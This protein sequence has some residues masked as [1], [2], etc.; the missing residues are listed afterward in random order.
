MPQVKSRQDWA[1][2]LR[3]IHVLWTPGR[4][5]RNCFRRATHSSYFYVML[6]RETLGSAL[7]KPSYPMKTLGWV[8]IGCTYTHI[9][10]TVGFRTITN[11]SSWEL[12]N[13]LCLKSEPCMMQPCFSRLKSYIHTEGGIGSRSKS[14]ERWL[15]HIKLHISQQSALHLLHMCL[16]SAQLKETMFCNR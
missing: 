8:S 9:V 7:R 15:Q 1:A 4:K 12:N 2:L 16:S 3:K 6:N 10:E 5:D 13:S 11:R 14:V